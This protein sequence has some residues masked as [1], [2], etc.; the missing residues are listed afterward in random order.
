MKKIILLFLLCMK[1]LCIEDFY[2]IDKEPLQVKIEK[3]IKKYDNFVLEFLYKYKIKGRV[4]AIKEYYFDNLSGLITHDIGVT[5]GIMSHTKYF[6]QVEW[7]QSNRLLNFSFKKKLIDEIGENN[8]LDHIANV[9]LI[10]KNKK[11][12]KEIE[13]IKKN[14]IVTFYGYLV[15]IKKINK[16]YYEYAKTSITRTDRGM[17]ACEIMYVI[18][19]DINVNHTRFF[20]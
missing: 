9:H 5:W 18:K 3:Q 15:N 13:K 11:I 6:N 4:V 1:L 20:N 14:D 19:V 17:G 10:P 12:K 7:S 16:K 8:M 2:S